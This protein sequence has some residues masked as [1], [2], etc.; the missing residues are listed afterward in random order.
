MQ[1]KTIGKV[2]FIFGLT[3]LFVFAPLFFF[4]LL[5][6]VTILDPFYNLFNNEVFGFTPPAG[7]ALMLVG[8]LIY[9]KAVEEEKSK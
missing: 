7:I 5:S 1:N 9:A 6:G 8:G 3:P 4:R 2:F